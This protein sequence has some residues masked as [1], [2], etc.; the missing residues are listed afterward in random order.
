[1]ANTRDLP[2]EYIVYTNEHPSNSSEYDPYKPSSDK[3]SLSNNKGDKSLSNSDSI[4]SLPSLP[5]NKTLSDQDKEALIPKV[6]KT[7]AAYQ[8]EHVPSTDKEL[9][10]HLSPYRDTTY[11]PYKEG[12]YDKNK[13]VGNRRDNQNN[14]SSSQ[15]NSSDA[16]TTSGSLNPTKQ[17][18][19]EFVM[20]KSE[21]EMPNIIPDDE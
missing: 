10:D 7:L 16:N 19:T 8:G 17:T 6:S 18:P 5:S 1:M 13:Y 20:E 9:K 11:D 15:N 14:S 21:L 3:D 4:G 12:V 2:Y